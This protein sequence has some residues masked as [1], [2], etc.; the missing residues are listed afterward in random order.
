[1]TERAFS[2]GLIAPGRIARNFA[3]ALAVVPNAELYAVASSNLARAQAFADEFSGQYAYD[4]YQRLAEDPNVDAI[5]IANPHRFHFDSIKMCLEAGK[6]VL[7]EKPLTVNAAQTQAL[8]DIAEQNKV[9]LMEALWTRF[10]PS[11]QQVR[12]WLDE[13]LIGDIKLMS[14]SFGFNIPRDDNDRLLNIDLA[15]GCL[16]DMGVYNVSMSQFVMQSNPTKILA[17][18][19]V[20]ETGVDERSSV[21]LNY[22]NAASQFTCNFLATTENDFTIYG[23]KGSIR[24]PNMFWVGTKASLRVDGQAEQMLDFPFK[25]SGFEYQIEEVMQCVAAGKL[26]S[27]VMGWQD[28][29]ATMQTMD[30][31][32][33]QVGV[34]YPFLGE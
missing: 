18:G 24:V 31:I 9:F 28:S 34:R 19:I 2:W 4:D 21:I 7:C 23:T 3:E 14:S 22:G 13:Q 25:A 15:G 30:E 33:A 1:M 17:D 27:E 12:R 26:Q 32:R 10:Q 6:P 20:G 11:W 29:I 8:V 16:L 5:Y